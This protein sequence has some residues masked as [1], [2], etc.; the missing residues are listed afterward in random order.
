MDALKL[1]RIKLYCLS[2][3]KLDTHSG[4]A[5]RG[6]S[7]SWLPDLL[8]ILFNCGSYSMVPLGARA[9]GWGTLRAAQ[10]NTA[11]DTSACIIPAVVERALG[12]DA[13]HALQ[14]DALS[15]QALIGERTR[16]YPDL[17]MPPGTDQFEISRSGVG[18]PENHSAYLAK[19]YVRYTLF[20][21]TWI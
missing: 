13:K 11:G 2:H 5:M 9:N 7:K 16:Q 14:W 3:C 6:S 12:Y 8:T 1:G 18:W 20:A 17:M 19:P 4:L 10:T 15:Q 21:S